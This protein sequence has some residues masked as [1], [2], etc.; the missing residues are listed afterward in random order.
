MRNPLLAVIFVVILAPLVH[1]DNGL[2]TVKSAHSVKQT[3]DRLDSLLQEKG[4]TVFGRVDHAAGAKKVEKTLR[5]NELLIFGN[6]KVGTPLMQCGQT[7]AIDLPQ[8]MLVWE[9]A[10][11]QVWLTYNDPTYLAKRHGIAQCGDVIIKI[12]KALR[13]FANTA[14]R[15]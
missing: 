14:A 7:V 15:P 9:D 2:V 6:P 11:G 10:T 5:P 8:K 3:A 4:M 13:N 12:G 1:A